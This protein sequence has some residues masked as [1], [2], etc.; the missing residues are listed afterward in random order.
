MGWPAAAGGLLRGA[1]SGIPA[2]AA[3][4]ESPLAVAVAQPP[5]G[6]NGGG[7]LRDA[8]V[9]AGDSAP[10]ELWVALE[11]VDAISAGTPLPPEGIIIVPPGDRVFRLAGGYLRFV[12]KCAKEGGIRGARPEVDRADPRVLHIALESGMRRFVEPRSILEKLRESR[13]ADLGP[14]ATLWSMRFMIMRGVS[15]GDSPRRSSTRPPSVCINI[16]ACAACRT[17]LWRMTGWT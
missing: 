1:P 15:C 2:V 12:K 9:S 11:S 17:S 10:S 6:L 14:Q 8:L 3:A 7:L 16:R 5:P 13:W 4:L